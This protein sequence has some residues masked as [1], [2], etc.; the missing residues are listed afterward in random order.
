MSRFT[1]AGSELE[2]FAK[3]RN[4]K[5]YWRGA[6][7]PYVGG[8]VLEVGAGIGANTVLFEG[9]RYDEWICLEPDAALCGQLREKVRGLRAVHAVRSTIGGL[10]ER[11]RFD[12]ILYIDVL[13]HIEDDRGE[14][15]QAVS[16][17]RPG[18]H[19]MVLGPAHQRLYTPFDRAIGHFRRYSRSSLR[20]IVP[21]QL[22][23]VTLR[24]LDAAGLLASAANRLLQ[25]SMPTDAQIAF[26]DRWLVPVSRIVD[27]ML[28]YGVGK[29]LLG[30]WRREA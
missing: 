30:V 12:S 23:P 9:C 22:S 6:L 4:W 11:H 13:E 3:A 24:Y 29:S 27:P 18:G 26:W 2:L 16:R 5:R 25:Q 28:R 1:Y 15:Q 8:R 19:V 10:P 7:L 17:L 20:A 21:S 14:L